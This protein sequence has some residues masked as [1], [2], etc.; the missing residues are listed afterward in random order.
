[1]KVEL[2]ANSLDLSSFYRKF[3]GVMINLGWATKPSPLLTLQSLS[4]SDLCPDG[5]IFIWI[6]KA[7]IQPVWKILRAS[8]F[9]Y[10]E[11]LTWI[12]L[13]SNN[14]VQSIH[15]EDPSIL[16]RSHIALYIFRRG[17]R[18]IE[19][20]HQ[21]SSDVVL[22]VFRDDLTVP[23]EVYEAIETMLPTY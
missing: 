18:D 6:P 19:I 4:L 2:P 5:F 8:G 1:V 22:D 10:V 16:P 11:S 20:R 14:K 15:A 21:R 9:K 3:I 13:K 7:F 12:Q 23:K 17:G